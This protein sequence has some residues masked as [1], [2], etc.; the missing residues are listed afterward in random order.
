[1]TG[2]LLLNVDYLFMLSQSLGVCLF[3][4]GARY[5]CWLLI[6]QLINL[7]IIL[8]IG[9]LGRT[10]GR[11]TGTLALARVQ[12]LPALEHPVYDGVDLANVV[13]LS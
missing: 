2:N 11:K 1:M 9:E 4:A 6:T 13:F 10:L 12:T 7:P 8:P 5:F 3:Y